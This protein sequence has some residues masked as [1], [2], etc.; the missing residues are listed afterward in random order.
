M[1]SCSTAST[2]TCQLTPFGCLRNLGD[3]AADTRAGAPLPPRPMMSWA[4]S[5]PI[6]CANSQAASGCLVPFQMM[7]ELDGSRVQTPAVPVGRAPTFHLKLL[8]FWRYSGEQFSVQPEMAM[9]PS[10]NDGL[11][12]FF[13]SGVG[14]TC[15]FQ[16]RS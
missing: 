6:N 8:I 1:P 9:V 16:V 15:S 14:C 12:A 5:P 11:F 3:F 2:K 4:V 10:T 13:S 7:A